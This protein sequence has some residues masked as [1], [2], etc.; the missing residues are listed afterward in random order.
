MK[1]ADKHRG[2]EPHYDKPGLLTGPL[3]AGLDGAGG[4]PVDNPA[5]EY[6]HMA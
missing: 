4:S 2:V 6:D 1:Y 3:A 5:I